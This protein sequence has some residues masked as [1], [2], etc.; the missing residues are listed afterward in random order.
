MASQNIAYQYV[1]SVVKRRWLYFLVPFVVVLACTLV[2]VSVWPSI[3]RSSATILV[4]SQQ[5]PG[6]LVRA[7]V[8]ARAN[9]RIQVIEQR[10]RARD[11]LLKIMRKYSLFEDRRAKSNWLQSDA[12]ELMRG[13]INI[14]RLS[15]AGLRGRSR[16]TIAFNVSF[17]Y[18]K[19]AIAARVANEL[20][21]YILSLDIRTRTGYAAQT[22]KFLEREKDRLEKALSSIETEISEFKGKN[23]NSLPSALRFNLNVLERAEQRQRANE[24]EINEILMKMKLIDSGGDVSD[25]QRGNMRAQLQRL[26]LELIGKEITFSDSHPEIRRLR[27]QVAAIEKRLASTPIE[28]PQQKKIKPDVADGADGSAGGSIEQQLLQARLKEL[29]S[30]QIELSKSIDKLQSYIDRTPQVELALKSLTRG[31]ENLKKDFTAITRKESFAALGEKLEENKQGERFEVIEQATVSKTPIKPNRL[32]I[33]ALG[34]LAAFGAGGGLV[35]ALELLDN[36]IRVSGDLIEQFDVVPMVSIP[37]IPSRRETN[38]A[39]LTRSFAV[40]GALAGIAI[41]LFLVDQYYLPLS[42]L[43]DKA[44]KFV[45]IR[46]G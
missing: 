37:Y 12:I 34:V 32:M 6:D 4:E 36:H 40:G 10:I 20:V 15:L 8:T 2:V 24:R 45:F 21:T 11:N 35:A 1:F 41:G 14:E 42:L 16:P 18:E 7:T 46:M 25:P 28:S 31:Y 5:I 19:P 29:Q 22:T 39:V 9:E 33:L 13:R 44:L 30:Q 26:K 38:R 43:A 17:D 23:K 3:Y 27:K